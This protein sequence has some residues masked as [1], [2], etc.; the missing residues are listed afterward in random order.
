MCGFSSQVSSC[1]SLRHVKHDV[2]PI[3][4]STAVK[5]GH[6]NWGTNEEETVLKNVKG[7]VENAYKRIW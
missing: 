1:F 5:S 3:C 6:E 2:V 7:A 4:L